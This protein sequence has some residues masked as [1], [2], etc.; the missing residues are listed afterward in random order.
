MRSVA[1]SYLTIGVFCFLGLRTMLFSS[2]NLFRRSPEERVCSF[3]GSEK[4][5]PEGVMKISTEIINKTVASIQEL[6]TCSME[7]ARQRLDS[8]TKPRESWPS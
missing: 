6:D 1:D 4:S 2:L 8:L 7:M 5:S 3:G